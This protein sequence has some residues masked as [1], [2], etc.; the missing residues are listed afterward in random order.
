[1][2]IQRVR[3][4]Y[5]SATG[6]T[7]KVAM[8][9][10]KGAAYKL[11]KPVTVTNIS[12]P[13][14]R[15]KEISFTPSDLVIVA[16][17]TYAG[18]VPNKILPYFQNKITGNGALVVPVVL[19]GN[20]SFDNALAELCAELE[21]HGFHTVSAAAFVGQHAF[22]TELAHGRP[23][24]Q[25]LDQAEDFG[26][27]VAE[28]LLSLTE[29]PAPVQVPGD[30]AAPYYTPLGTDGQP[31]KFLKAKPVTDMKK[32][33]QCGVCAAV[34]PMGAI[35]PKNVASVPGT[36]IKCQACVTKCPL[37]AKYF[38]DPAFLSHKAM[39]EENYTRPA[40]SALFL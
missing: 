29:T 36:C 5:F 34:C 15:A 40:E 33:S 3:V 19:F 12:L 24:A 13:M 2:A 23:N 4:V 37:D 14:T 11:G 22:A 16:T 7:E 39:L 35:D 17:P 30:P 9:V 6:S 1:M 10:A 8:A 27:K 32:C 26:K 18:R 21:A 28:K 20:R 38:D 31:A 25:D